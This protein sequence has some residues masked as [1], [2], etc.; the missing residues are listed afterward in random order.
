MIKKTLPFALSLAL[1]VGFGGGVAIADDHADHDRTVGQVIDD[2]TITASIKTKLMDDERTEA[3]D[4]NVTTKSGVV[5]LKGGADSEAARDVA[6]HI[7]RTT[8]GVVSVDNRIVVAPEG[9]LARRE[10]NTAT[11]SG[12]ARAEAAELGEKSKDA[13]LTTKVKSQLLAE[14]D[15]DGSKI[16][17]ETKNEVVHLSGVIESDTMKAMAIRI[18]E[19][20]EGVRDVDA[21]RLKVIEG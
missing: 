19:N 6:T 12:E 17:V 2:S 9:S 7:A 5:T 16:N 3:F 20:T 10:A 4:I 1:G 15:V 8:E 21:K 11:L 14:D 18:A 13:W